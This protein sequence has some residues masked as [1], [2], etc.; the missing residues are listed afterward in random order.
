[1]VTKFGEELTSAKK[2]YRE[3]V[4]SLITKKVTKS[5][6]KNELLA[7][8]DNESMLYLSSNWSTGVMEMDTPR[9]ELKKQSISASKVNLPKFDI[10][11]A[12]DY[13]RSDFDS[14]S[15][16]SSSDDDDDEKNHQMK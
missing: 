4:K 12:I 13:P 16:S 10:Q 15:D 9:L 5:E 6:K 14:D 11:K 7:D 8:A 2:D 3:L 1:M